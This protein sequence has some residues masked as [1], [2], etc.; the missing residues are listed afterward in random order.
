MDEI[1]IDNGV[2]E[3]EGE[4][5]VVKAWVKDAL[6]GTQATWNYRTLTP[7]EAY[8]VLRLI[9]ERGWIWKQKIL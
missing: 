5:L 1:F 2:L 6:E 7:L 9:N 3:M 8:K 4:K